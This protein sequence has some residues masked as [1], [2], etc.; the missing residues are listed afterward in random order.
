[1][2][3]TAAT[4]TCGACLMRL[5][6]PFG[7][8]APERAS[9]WAAA[10][11]AARAHGVAAVRRAPT[12]AGGWW[13]CTGR[14]RAMH[15][16]S[17]RAAQSWQRPSHARTVAAQTAFHSAAQEWHTDDSTI[18]ALSS[19]PG[20][21]ALAV[22]RISGPHAQ[23]VVLACTR[24]WSREPAPVGDVQVANP[25]PAVANEHVLPPRRYVR[26]RVERSYVLQRTDRWA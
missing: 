12:P 9:M 16:H 22:V 25:S 1:M 7:T 10:Q 13:C 4:R 21:A 20:K 15:C 3:R 26:V 19:A 5:A 14:P 11:R 6:R 23:D 17:D 8:N 18:V 2:A 24:K